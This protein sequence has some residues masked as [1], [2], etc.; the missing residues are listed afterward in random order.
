MVSRNEVGSDK[1]TTRRRK[2]KE[3]IQGEG[4]NEADQDTDFT[5]TRL[6]T[7]PSILKGG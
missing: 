1:N 7:Q 3:K 5:L 2:K 4:G 6:E